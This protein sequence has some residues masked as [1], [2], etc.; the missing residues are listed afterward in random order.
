MPAVML[1]KW[2]ILLLLVLPMCLFAGEEQLIR[3][4]CVVRHGERTPWSGGYT[5]LRCRWPY[6]PGE[7]TPNGLNQAFM[8]GRQYATRYITNLHLLPPAYVP[9]TVQAVSTELNRTVLSA[10]ALLAGLYAADHTNRLSPQNIPILVIPHGQKGNLL[11]KEQEDPRVFNLNIQ[12]VLKTPEFVTLNRKHRPDLERWG[13]LVGATP[14]IANVWELVGLADYVF[15]MLHASP[16]PPLPDG[17]T[18][19]EANKIV[20]TGFG[21]LSRMASTPFMTRYM[22]SDFMRQLCADF[23]TASQTHQEGKLTLYVG[24]DI[25]I[26]PL[27]A[28][29][30]TPLTTN[31]PFAS[32]MEFELY[33]SDPD[34]YTVK[35]FYQDTSVRVAGKDTPTLQEFAEAIKW[36]TAP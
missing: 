18:V 6:P 35:V 19:G 34:N 23:E 33:R 25:S 28:A 16:P 10:Q 8:L 17:L 27:M 26:L 7:L 31:A 20:D 24:H 3:A 32:H 4:V 5:N 29:L 22:A 21:S 9:Q 1:M 30:R 14:P 13:G 36:V 2:T 11:S 15:C 12:K